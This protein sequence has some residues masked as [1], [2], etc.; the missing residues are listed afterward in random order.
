LRKKKTLINLTTGIGA[1]DKRGQRKRDSG[2][3][4]S[5]VGCKQ[6]AALSSSSLK[7]RK[8]IPLVANMVVP[9]EEHGKKKKIISSEKGG[10]K[11]ETLETELR[12]LAS[13]QQGEKNKRR[14]RGRG[15]FK[16]AKKKNA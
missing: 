14:D 2:K 4:G 12:L 10:E 7:K 15:R 11:V 8:H 13:Q 16:T 3:E 9:N 1:S 6:T 5:Q